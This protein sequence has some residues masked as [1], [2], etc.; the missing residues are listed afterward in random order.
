MARVLLE[1]EEGCVKLSALQGIRFLW[2]SMCKG[3]LLCLLPGQR[4]PKYLQRNYARGSIKIKHHVADRFEAGKYSTY[5]IV[6]MI[7]MNL[8]HRPA[9]AASDCIIYLCKVQ[10]RVLV[11]CTC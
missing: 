7:G 6:G 9:V 5:C 2:R 10:L 1:I 4:W 11:G 3:L 8:A